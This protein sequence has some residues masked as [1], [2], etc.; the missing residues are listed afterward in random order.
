MS[1]IATELAEIIKKRRKQALFTQQDLADESNVAVSTIRDLERGA[2]KDPK[3]STL[4]KLFKTLNIV[5]K[6]K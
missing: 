2:L 4:L 1:S 3:I 6:I 5:F